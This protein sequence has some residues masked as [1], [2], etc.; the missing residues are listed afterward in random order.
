MTGLPP[1]FR[2]D[3]DTGARLERGGS[4]LIG[5]EPFAIV[6]LE[7]EDAR[8]LAA[9]RAGAPVGDA[10]RGRRLGRTLV[11]RN[12]ALPVPPPN[13]VA[14][15][16]VV[17]PVRDRPGPLARLLAALVDDP[18]VER[19]VVVDD[20]SA[21]P[22]ATRRVTERFRAELVRLERSGGPGAARNAGLARVASPLVAFIDS[23][24]VPRPGWIAHLLPHFG[25]PAVALVAP[26]VVA[27]SEQG[28][29]AIA[30]YEAARAPFDRGPV[31]AAV[32]P[33][34]R[35]PFVPGAALVARREALGAGFDESLPVGQDVELVWRL[36]AGGGVR[37]EPAAVV[38]HHQGAELGGWLRRRVT[39]GASAA[40]LGRRHPGAARPLAMSPW[41]A[42]AWA[43]VGLRRPGAA[44][45]IVGLACGLLGRGLQREVG[46]TTWCARTAIALAGGGTLRS[47]R[48]VAD[49]LVRAW[50]PL[51]LAGAAAL[52][53]ARCRSPQRRSSPPC[54]TGRRGST[55]CA[56]SCFASRTTRPMDA[57]SGSA[58]CA[59]A[60]PEPVR[61][62]LAWRLDVLSSGRAHLTRSSMR[63]AQQC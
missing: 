23:D 63:N 30:R 9:W 6:R 52:P 35:V 43:A 48:G 18:G 24:C 47:G 54:S 22:Q 40:P 61:P 34:G 26:R 59:S 45:A 2:L 58:A 56:G 19:V 20:G 4:V 5:G 37:Y 21:D 12:F 14:A 16:T 33:G 44:A 39:Y 28:G 50:A 25:D 32:R 38:E 42:G 62:D 57:A 27:R 17:V 3:F 55:R 49:A 1:G 13:D 29:G 60:P 15:L 10:P 41:T 46:D 51:A 7:P 36:A 11:A 8:A 31:A 53:R